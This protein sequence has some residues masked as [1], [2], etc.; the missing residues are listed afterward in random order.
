MDSISPKL[1]RST[2][3]SAVITRSSK[4]EDETNYKKKALLYGFTNSKAHLTD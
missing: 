1:I 4:A 2:I 3:G